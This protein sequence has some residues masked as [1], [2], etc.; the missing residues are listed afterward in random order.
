[1]KKTLETKCF[2]AGFF[3]G[4]RSRDVEVA[5]LRGQIETLKMGL[6]DIVNRASKLAFL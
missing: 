4:V 6:N 1:M 2:D 5:K 3:A